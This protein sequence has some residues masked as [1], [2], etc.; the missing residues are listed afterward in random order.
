METGKWKLEN[1][2]WKMETGKWKV[3]DGNYREHSNGCK[4]RQRLQRLG[5]VEDGA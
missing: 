1:G 4:A 3:E 2:N 5:G